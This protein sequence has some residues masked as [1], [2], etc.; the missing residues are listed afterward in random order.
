METVRQHDRL[1]LDEHRYEEPKEIFKFLVQRVEAQHGKPKP[2][3]VIYDVGCAAGEFPYYLE[4]TWPQAEIV[5]Y[6]FLPELVERARQMVPK[7]RF[8][9]GSVLDP[10]M[11]PA[12][13]ADIVFVVGVLTIFDDFR[14]SVDNILSWLKPGG[15]GY[16]FGIFNPSPIDVIVRSRPANAGA[17]EPWETGWNLFSQASV[18]TYLQQHPL[19][20]R[21]SFAPF[22]MPIDLPPNK[23]DALRSWTVPMGDGQRMLVNGLCIIHHFMALEIVRPA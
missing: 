8:L 3:A 11:A 15:V 2:G 23:T 4:K 19:R 6:D 13:S 9:T 12:A 22:S 14:P 1:Y 20:P 17:D 21:F 10:A 5:G 16:V 7:V 18:E